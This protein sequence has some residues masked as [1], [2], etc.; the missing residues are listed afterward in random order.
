MN[1]KVPDDIKTTVEKIGKRVSE[2][3]EIKKIV[4]VGGVDE[5]G[6][7]HTTTEVHKTLN[8][9]GHIGD[10]G[11][12]CQVCGSSFMVCEACAKGGLF[13]C[14]ICHR[15]FCPEHSIESIFHPG[16]RF[17]HRCGFRGLLMEALKE[18]R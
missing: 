13:T 3:G 15:I 10:T 2:T 18:R 17:C 11:G 9:C 1:K 7:A 14:D 4:T 8:D 6:T 16:V 5:E 12:T